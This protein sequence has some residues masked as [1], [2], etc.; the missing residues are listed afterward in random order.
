MLAP[1]GVRMGADETPRGGWSMGSLGGSTRIGTDVL[2][3][4]DDIDRTE[5][6]LASGELACPDCRGE[7]RPW[8]H[9]RIRRLRTRHATRQLRPRRACCRGCGRTHVL[10]PGVCL[11]RRADAVEVIG[12]AV[13]ANVAGQ[14]HRPIAARLGRPEATVRGWLRRFRARAAQT[15]NRA[16]AWIYRLDVTAFRIEPARNDTPAAF[17]LEALGRAVMAAERRLGV[18]PGPP[19]QGVSSLCSGRLLSHTSCPYPQM[20]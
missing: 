8:G 7:L 11:L 1:A 3:V 6:Q 17:A 19:W 20:W 12:E 16:V 14:G 10:L 4:P 18:R 9:A 5:R 13:V 2:I 15:A